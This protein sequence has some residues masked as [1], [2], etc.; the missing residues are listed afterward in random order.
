LIFNRVFDIELNSSETSAL[1]PNSGSM[2]D[3]TQVNMSLLNLANALNQLAESAVARASIL[4]GH[5]V[6]APQCVSQAP[7][8]KAFHALVR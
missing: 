5:E 1:D 2:F 3:A 6:S 7:D 4:S 8:D